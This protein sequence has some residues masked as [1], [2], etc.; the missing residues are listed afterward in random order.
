[1]PSIQN[2]LKHHW[3]F[4]AKLLNYC[5][6]TQTNPSPTSSKGMQVGEKYT[7]YFCFVIYYL[8]TPSKLRSP[9]WVPSNLS[10]TRS[11]TTLTHTRS[12]VPS[13]LCV[14]T[15][16]TH[17]LVAQFAIRGA[18]AFKFKFA[19]IIVGHRAPRYHNKKES[20]INETEICTQTHTLTRAWVRF[21]FRLATL[22]RFFHRGKVQGVFVWCTSSE[23]C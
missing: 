19:I 2:M 17:V 13:R 4:A 16:P 21:S 9:F 8:L 7:Q 18:A 10:L 23:A 12:K 20:E 22:G 15:Y 3:N 5:K 1:M 11:L 6:H 14:V